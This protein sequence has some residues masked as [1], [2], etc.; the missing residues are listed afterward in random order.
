MKNKDKIP[1]C[2]TWLEVLLI[3]FCLASV[4]FTLIFFRFNL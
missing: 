2:L 3:I 1:F 4:V